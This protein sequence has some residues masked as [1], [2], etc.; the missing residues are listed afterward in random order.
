MST[1]L[2]SEFGVDAGQLFL[3]QSRGAEVPQRALSMQDIPEWTSRQ[4]HSYALIVELVPGV[5]Q[6]LA[7]DG[8]LDDV[9]QLLVDLFGIDPDTEVKTIPWTIGYL[10]GEFEDVYPRRT[11]TTRLRQ[12]IAP[13][14]DEF[15]RQFPVR[16]QRGQLW[17]TAA[18]RPK[19]NA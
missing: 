12:L 13:T 10:D 11:N 18:V 6:C 1:A 7:L 19:V 5:A 9:E 3:D 17:F 14:L 8:T 15:F 2:K 4:T 16:A